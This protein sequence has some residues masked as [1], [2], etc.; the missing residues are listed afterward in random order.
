MYY[1]TILYY[2]YHIKV[3]LEGVVA[4]QKKLDTDIVL[5]IFCCIVTYA[6]S[7][8]VLSGDMYNWCRTIGFNSAVP[9]DTIYCVML[10]GVISVLLSMCLVILTCI[11]SV[12]HKHCY[13]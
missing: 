11:Y 7:Y 12:L 13:R 3:H 10:I 5:T 9:A 8:F 6:L 2:V 1:D 4:M